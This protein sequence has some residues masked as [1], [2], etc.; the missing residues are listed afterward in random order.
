M[1]NYFQ[2][3]D[4]NMMESFLRGM[5]R[6]EARIGRADSRP[7]PRSD[8]RSAPRRSN[9]K[10]SFN[11][12]DEEKSIVIYIDMSGIP[13]E[14]ISIEFDNNKVKIQGE[15]VNPLPEGDY[16]E[17]YY[18]TVERVI[19]LPICVTQRE[20]ATVSYENGMLKIVL[21]KTK[22]EKNRFR[23]NV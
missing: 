19:T 4:P 3:T 18:G 9:S 6:E 11:I 20:T 23:I 5:M 12:K 16:N 10:P 1:S 7:D 17:I 22:E 2:I 15:K 8:S 13:R 21:D 14:Q